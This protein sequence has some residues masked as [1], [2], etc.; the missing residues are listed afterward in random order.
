[1][2]LT[3]LWDP[4]VMGPTLVHLFVGSKKLVSFCYVGSLKYIALLCTPLIV[5]MYAAFSVLCH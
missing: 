4:K 2:D 5:D 1:M 3:M